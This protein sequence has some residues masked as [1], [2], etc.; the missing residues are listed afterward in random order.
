MTSHLPWY[1]CHVLLNVSP[2]F[3]A[4]CTISTDA[5]ILSVT[6]HVINTLYESQ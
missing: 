1:V 3:C 6:F 4:G 5:Y 2:L